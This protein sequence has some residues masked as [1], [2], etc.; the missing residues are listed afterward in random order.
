MIK[1][2]V[3]LFFLLVL[4]FS[5]GQNHKLVVDDNPP[6]SSVVH[7]PFENMT[8]GENET[9][10]LMTWNLKEFPISGNTTVQ[11]VAEALKYLSVDIIAFQEI[12]NATQF[13][14]MVNELNDIDS[15]NTWEGYRSTGAYAE[16][17]LAYIYKTNEI[18]KDAIYRILE[19]QHYALPRS[20]LVFE[21]EFHN[22]H[23]VSIANH[24]KASGDAE[25]V[26]RRMQ[27]SQELYDYINSHF[28]NDNVIMLG[29]LNDELT[30]PAD[31]N[32]FQ[33][34]L[35][36]P[37]HYKFTDYDIAQGPSSNWSYPSWP[38]HIDH[39]MISNELFDEFSDYRSDIQTIKPDNYIGSSEYYHYISDHRPVALKLYV[40]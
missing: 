39:I 37:T 16:I 34:F 7:S 21:F 2:F 18:A 20:P 5:C 6:D 40:D 11:K 32:V 8:F 26:Q 14:N 38:S 23:F 28:N 12:F 3:F 17:N 9:L 33:I 24:Y 35:D 36:D 22:K 15:L 1:K 13:E 4:I 31:E 25:S 29:D 19:N 30:D 10:E 27:A